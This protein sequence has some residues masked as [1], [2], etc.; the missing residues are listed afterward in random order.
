M[1][2]SICIL[3]FILAYNLI[4]FSYGGTFSVDYTNHVFLKDGQPY[5]Y[6]AGS[7]HYWRIHRDYW[8][9]RLQRAKALGLTAISTYI[10]WFLHEPMQ[11]TL[12]FTGGL[13]VAHYLTLAQENQL[14]VL[15]RPGPY[16]DS[17][18]EFGGL[19]YWL[20]KYDNIRLRASVDS[21]YT[22]AVKNY[23][24]KLLDII[25]PFLYKNGG[26]ILMVQIENEYGLA[27]PCDHNYTNW[28]RDF[29]W[30]KLGNDVVLYTTDPT[31]WAMPCGS[32]PGA[33]TTADFHTEGNMTIIDEDFAKQDNHSN[34]APHAVDEFYP[35]AGPL[36]WGDGWGGGGAY[37]W[38]LE[39]I[40]YMYKTSKAS[41]SFYMAHGGTNFGFTSGKYVAT[42]YWVN[43]PIE[44]NGDKHYS[45]L[46]I[47]SAIINMTNQ[48]NLPPVPQ[49]NPVTYYGQVTLTQIGNSLVS[50][51]GKIQ[52]TCYNS[53]DPKG[54]EEIDHGYGYVLYSTTLT[55]SGRV[56]ATP[57]ILDFGY[58]YLNNVYQ[59]AIYNQNETITFLK[60][61]QA[62]D[63]LKILVENRGR[64][65]RIS[66]YRDLWRNLLEMKGLHTNASIDGIALQNWY[67]CG[68][69]LTKASI[70]SLTNNFFEKSLIKPY[71]IKAI[72]QP[73]VYTGQ[74]TA[75]PITDTFLDP[76]GWG[77]GQLFVNG[78]NLGRYWPTKGPQITLYIPK[79]Y[80][81]AQNTITLI[82]LN[83]AQQNF[84]NLTD[85]QIFRNK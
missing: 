58:V 45:Y 38:F 47:R 63:S 74:F 17:E 60:S 79:P 7:M 30:S 72:S 34:G 62:G 71:P 85:H 4:K 3:I 46:D 49:N 10:P 5:Q 55:R 83:G 9:D 27:G 22:N 11:G 80:L 29:M 50:T 82:E 68:I 43:G 73:G 61:V 12:D 26:P 39:D 1:N 56:L 13:D 57:N 52:E 76:T 14:Y 48:Q 33:V 75:S 44:E 8:N 36:L 84:V 19:P 41:M 51:L 21:N 24:D 53:P 28:L 81:Q 25:K 64:S 42:T 32:V 67:S 15:L 77:M 18:V 37:G 2:K 40:Q 70:D 20:L 31:G 35:P 16:I 59:G 66:N 78:Y 69:N 6:V 23:F 65:P 54:F